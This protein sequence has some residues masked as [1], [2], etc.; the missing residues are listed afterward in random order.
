VVAARRDPQHDE[1][2]AETEQ[3]SR[4]GRQSNENPACVDA[5]PQPRLFEI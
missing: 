5:E 2:Q 4:P 1:R 3:S